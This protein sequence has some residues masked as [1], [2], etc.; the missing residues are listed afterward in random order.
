MA[1]GE[2]Q[3]QTG[4]ENQETKTATEE[5]APAWAQEMVTGLGRLVQVVEASAN[6]QTQPDGNSTQVTPREAEVED[7]VEVD[8]L[9]DENLEILPRRDF[10][11]RM[12][13][14]FQQIAERTMKPLVDEVHDTRQAISTEQYTREAVAFAERTPDFSEWKDEMMAIAKENPNLSI[15]RIYALAKAENP[16]KAQEIDT[17]LSDARKKDEEKRAQEAAKKKKPLA[18]APSG[19]ASGTPRNQKMSPKEAAEAAWEETIEKFGGSPFA[20]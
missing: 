2:N 4:G 9:D 7:E 10:A 14:S 11:R 1:E 6:R 12:M 3:T 19:P 5:K 20:A 18:L 17:K 8:P 13:E 15:A 16:Q